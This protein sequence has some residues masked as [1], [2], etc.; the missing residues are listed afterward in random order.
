MLK[1]NNDIQSLIIGLYKNEVTGTFRD[2]LLE[3][4][5]K[6]YNMAYNNALDEVLKKISEYLKNE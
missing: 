2:G 4:E 3:M 5:I 6:D 1:N